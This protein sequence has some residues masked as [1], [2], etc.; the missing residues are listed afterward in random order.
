MQRRDPDDDRAPAAQPRPRPTGP[1]GRRGPAARARGS[2]A[3]VVVGIV[4]A[5]L[6]L[7]PAITSLGAAPRRGPRRT[8]HERQPWPACSPPCRRSASRVFGVTA[9]RLARRFGAGA[10][11]C[12]GMAAIA[13]GLLIRP[14]AGGTAGF[15]AASALALD[16][17]RRQQRPDAGD[18]QAL[19]P[20]PGRLHDR[21]ST[22]WP[23]PSAPPP[24]RPSTVPMTEALGGSWRVG[25]RRLGACSPRSPCCPGS[26]L[27]RR[28]GRG[29]AATQAPRRAGAATRTAPGARGSPAAAPPGRSPA[30]SASRPPPPTSPWAGCRRSSATPGVPAGTAGLLLAVTMVMGVPLAFVIPRLATRMRH[31]GPIVVALGA[32]GLAGYAGLLLRTGR[33]RLGLGAAARHL[34]LRLPARPHHD[35]HAGQDRRRAWPS[36]R[37]SRRAP[38]I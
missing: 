8:R 15:L 33:R 31:Q 9:P 18:R 30:S 13:A 35:R 36:C 2:P 24:P 20:R 23:W 14:F 22:R 32:C 27:V 34:Q 1:R 7:R 38:A 21:A 6:N 3:C 19:L 25:P 17:H 12:A 16:G 28:P 29:R 11:V 26:P 5:A 37:P 4:L 10:V